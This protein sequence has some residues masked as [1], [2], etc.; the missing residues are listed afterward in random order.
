MVASGDHSGIAPFF[1]SESD[2]WAIFRIKNNA[3]S[4]VGANGR[5]T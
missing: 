2:E 5:I 3:I 1:F 4:T